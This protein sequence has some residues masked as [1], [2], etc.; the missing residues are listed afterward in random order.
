M[1]TAVVELEQARLGR[2]RK[3]AESGDLTQVLAGQVL[4]SRIDTTVSEALVL[5]LLAQDVRTFFCVFGH[6]STEVGEV[7][8]IYQAVGLL[9]VCAVRNEIEASHAAMALRWVTGEKAAVVTSI[10]PGALQ[11]LA[12]SIAPR[13]DGVGVWYLLGDETTEDEGPNMQQIP[14]SEQSVFLRLF[15]AMGGA[16]LLHTPLALAT[17][18][19]RGLNTVD[20]PHRAGPFFLLLPLNIQPTKLAQFNLAELPSG[21]PPALGPAVDEGVYATVVAAIAA[22]E[23]VVVKGGRWCAGMRGGIG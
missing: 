15:G 22:A 18:L 11:A 3:V 5:G 17:A 13:S 4:G 20:H 2:A 6:G 9:R 8:R 10:G 1:D 23:R 19:R 12:A 21:A 16:Y 14:G 7:L